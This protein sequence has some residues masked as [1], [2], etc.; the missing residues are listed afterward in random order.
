MKRLVF[1]LA[2]A[3]VL[4][5]AC[6]D[7]KSAATDIITTDYEAPQPQEPIA[8][9]AKTDR[10]DVSWVE[11]RHYTIQ[12]TRTPADSLPMVA[13]VN[14]QKYIDNIVKVEVLRADS[15]VFFRRSFTKSSF[16]EWLDAD[17]RKKG[18]LEGIS[19]H[20]QENSLRAEGAK[21]LFVAWV[22]YP[23]SGED[24]A[25]DLQISLGTTGDVSIQPFTED[26]ER[27]DLKVKGVEEEL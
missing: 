8:M 10:T 4:M 27:D 3:A 6:K 21:L 12:V 11:G 23:Q 13:D 25:V 7:K 22:N 24:E 20:R 5:V 16:A 15:S 1:F 2:A 14:G 26:D 9:S 17:Y 19:F 18:I